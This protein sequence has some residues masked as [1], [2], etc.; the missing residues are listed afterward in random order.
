MRQLDRMPQ[1]QIFRV[2]LGSGVWHVSQNGTFFGDYLNRGDAIRAACA[3]ARGEEGR[4]RAAQVF[5]APGAV[6][7]PHHE[8]HLGA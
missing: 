6:A 4:G 8:P 5:E 2:T 1:N 3:A 7:L